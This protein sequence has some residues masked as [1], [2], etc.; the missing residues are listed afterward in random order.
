M[1]PADS[2]GPVSYV[3]NQQT[4]TIQPGY[5]QELAADQSWIVTF[6]RGG[7]FGQAQYQLEPGKAYA[8]G[9]GKQG[10]EL[11]QST[12]TATL[13]NSA[14]PNPFN[15]LQGT[16]QGQVAAH[17]KAT[18]TANTPILLVFDPGNGQSARRGRKVRRTALG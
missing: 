16:E 12:Y 5:T 6:D 10:W 9:Q 14:N 3:L 13:D 18:L 2:G 17:Q 11:Y 7:S 8:F 15:Y 1:S 4:Y